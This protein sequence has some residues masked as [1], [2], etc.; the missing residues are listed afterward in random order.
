MKLSSLL[1]IGYVVSQNCNQGLSPMTMDDFI[2]ILK[3]V[4]IIMTVM[5]TVILIAK[6]RD[7]SA[8]FFPIPMTLI[9][10]ATKYLIIG[11]YASMNRLDNMMQILSTMP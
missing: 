4:F 3:I 9:Y 6:T 10:F 11:M 7:A 1:A 2:A 5:S 8:V